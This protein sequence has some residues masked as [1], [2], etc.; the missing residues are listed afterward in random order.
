[1]VKQPLLKRLGPLLGLLLFAVALWTVHRQLAEYR[2]Q[3]ITRALSEISSDRLILSLILTAASYLLLAGYD[4]LAFHYLERPLEYGKIARA[5]FIGYAFSNNIGFSMIAGSTIRYR[6]YSAWGLSALEVA[7]IITFIAAT[8]WLGLFS[9]GGVVFLSEPMALPNLLHL[10]FNTTRPIGV[11]LLTLVAGYF[12][13][14]ALFHRPVRIRGWEF[15]LPSPKLSFEQ[16]LLASADWVVASGALYVLLPPG[17]VPSYPVFLGI[18]LL[19]Q[20]AG[21]ISQV[22]GGLGILETIVLLLLSPEI[23]AASIAGALLLYRGIYYFLP[24]GL[25][26]LLLGAHELLERKEQVQRL[27]RTFGEWIPGMVPQVLAV[28]IFIGGTILLF[29]GATPSSEQR[30]QWLAKLL[31]LPVLELSHFLGS[32]VGLGLLLLAR[33]L[34]R[35]LDAAYL[36]TAALLGA[37]IVFSLLK[38]LDYEEAIVLTVMLAA[39]LPCRR[40]FYRRSSLTTERFTPGWISAISLILLG[41]AWLVAF[42]YKHVEYSGE[43]WWRFTFSEDAPRSLRATVGAISFA[44]LF[45]ITRLLR[46]APPEPTL[47]GRKEL[48]RAR[49]IIAQSPQTLANLA[50][51]G[52]KE[53]LFNKNSSAFMMYA[54][55]GQSWVALGDPI[56]PEGERGELTW[57]FRELCDLHGGWTVFYQAGRQCLPLYLDLGLT[58]LKIGE[59][60][61]VPLATFSLEGNERK[62]FRHTLHRLEK[63]ECRFELIPASE[64]PRLLPEMKVV[65]DAW[66]ADKQAREKRFSL[67]FFNEEYL[68]LFPAG[69]VRRK[70]ELIA[71][72]N[73]WLGAEK[74]ELSIDL[75]RYHPEAPPGV[76]DLLLI[77][78]ICWGQEEGYQWFNLGMAPLSGLEDHALGPLWSR[79]GTWIYRYGEHF[80]H[81][82]GL[83][84]YKEKFDPEWEPKYLASPGSL[85]LPH[86]LGDIAALIA[87]GWKGIVAK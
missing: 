64:V 69:V 54:V 74:A 59:E 1:M 16:I 20:I 7:K 65:S 24:L 37:G 66:L 33:G 83:R 5:S 86:I 85:L 84:E 41:S 49:S 57:Q 35:R 22:P 81:F 3:D 48:E 62:G 45:G 8:F 23:P 11:I 15:C 21:L 80:Y 38:G 28:T 51:L 87:G 42:S 56:G 50:L 73:V 58:L 36:L 4:I 43:L 6:L 18:F 52:D 26:A 71:F 9:I 63:E 79:V 47:P 14:S 53:L 77:K 12:I 68:K 60:A 17:E 76:M 82:Q 31:P 19:A 30:M 78:M 25:A 70:G 61:R 55:E 46:P 13:G 29:S 40:Y 39:L 67:G 44:V 27:S 2:Y 72:A 75:M 32:L 10:P 34:Q